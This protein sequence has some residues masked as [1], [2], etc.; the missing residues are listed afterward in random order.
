M[1]RM[2][3]NLTQAFGQI[4]SSITSS[5]KIKVS[6]ITDTLS[7]WVDP[8]DFA[9][10]ADGADITQYVTVKNGNKALTGGYTAT[11]GVD[12]SGNRTVTVTFN[13]TDGIVTEKDRQS[14]TYPSRSSQA[15]PPMPTYAEQPATTRM[16]E[17]ANT[18]SRIC[19]ASRGLLFQCG[20]AS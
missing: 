16:W 3:T 11:Y 13:G 14:S 4:Y 5:A 6:S 10:V 19:W 18:G 2:L 7:Q 9:G 8:V 15:M 1:A 12:Q 17:S 20:R